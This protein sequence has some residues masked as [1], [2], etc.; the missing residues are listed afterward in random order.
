MEQDKDFKL[1]DDKKELIKY[2]GD[3]PTVVIPEGVE[4]IKW[5]AF[6]ENNSVKEVILPSTINKLYDKAFMKCEELEHVRFQVLP[7]NFIGCAFCNCKNLNETIIHGDTLVRVP[8]STSGKYIIPKGIVNIGKGAFCDCANI[9]ELVITPG[10]KNIKE[11]A[12]NG[13]LNLKSISI[14][15]SVESIE[16]RAFID[17][18]KVEKITIDKSNPKYDSRNDCNAI[19]ETKVNRIIFGC[20]KTVFV[21]TITSIGEHAFSY[22]SELK[23]LTLP[24]TI[25]EVKSYAFENC[26]N[27]KIAELPSSLKLVESFI[28]QECKNLKE[29]ILNE[30]IENIDFAA[31]YECDNLVSIN[32]PNSFIPEDLFISDCCFNEIVKSVK[33]PVFNDHLFISLP[34]SY[35]GHYVIPE[36]ITCINEYAFYGCETLTG[37]TFPDSIKEISESAFEKCSNLTKIIGSNAI[38]VIRKFAF[39]ECRELSSIELPNIERIE[40]KAFLNCSKL[41]SIVLSDDVTISDNPFRGCPIVNIQTINNVLYRPIIS[42]DGIVNLPATIKKIAPGAFE[43]C[44]VLKSIT[45]PSGVE[46]GAEAFSGCTN[47]QNVILSNDLTTLPPRAF[48]GCKTLKYID[49]PQNLEII[50]NAVFRGCES[51]EAITI[52]KSVFK[53]GEQAFKGCVCLSEVEWE[54]INSWELTEIGYAAFEGCRMLYTMKLPS[55]VSVIKGNAFKDCQNLHEIEFWSNSLTELGSSAFEG[56]SSLE[57]IEIPYDLTK[58]EEYTFKNCKSLRYVS[59]PHSV[60]TINNSAFSGCENIE[61]ADMS[62]GWDS[63]REKLGLPPARPSRIDYYDDDEPLTG[64]GATEDGP[65]ICTEGRMWPCPYCG[66]NAVQT[67]IDGTAQC[68]D[69]RRWYKYTQ[70]WF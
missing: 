59:V 13:L 65:M 47:L 58:I 53:M 10:V 33:T 60:K 39:E 41:N 68:N 30:G 17:C 4:S 2:E 26:D 61:T 22:C 56:C 49:L 45:I 44:T 3:N 63:K 40:D 57:S 54:N 64:L 37:V 67:Y 23:E 62:A 27:L 29:V 12:F 32:I 31:F 48:E 1:S 20:S 42:E 24:N 50:E 38:S 69:C 35:S 36:G 9:T 16:E 43:N 66:S 25:T 19:V 18:G 5:R 7:E 21:E 14:P 15:A 70:R 11:L 51:L 6:E 46:L 55:H 8:I 52:P 34:Q 28:F